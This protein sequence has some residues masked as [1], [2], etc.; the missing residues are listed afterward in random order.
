MSRERRNAGAPRLSHLIAIRVP[1]PEN[2]RD[3]EVVTHSSIGLL[4]AA[5]ARSAASSDFGV[6]D[7][8]RHV[9]PPVGITNAQM[10][11]EVVFAMSPQRA[12]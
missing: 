4:A 9:F 7:Y 12:V 1:W 11:R 2:S 3:A 10:S 8:G 5:Q 6:S